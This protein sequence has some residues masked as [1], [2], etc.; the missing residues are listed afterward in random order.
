MTFFLFFPR[1]VQHLLPP[2]V[3]GACLLMH[4]C[5]GLDGA[6]RKTNAVPSLFVSVMDQRGEFIVIT[7][8]VTPD[9]ETADRGLVVIGS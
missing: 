5:G 6:P 8:T 7:S 4:G 9:D 3:S 1:T 2:P